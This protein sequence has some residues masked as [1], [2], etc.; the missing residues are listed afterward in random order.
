[1]NNDVTCVVDKVEWLA[2]GRPEAGVWPHMTPVVMINASL[3]IG[4]VYH[5]EH[6][7]GRC[8]RGQE[9]AVGMV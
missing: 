8:L 7:I 5:L 9:M 6:F 2:P 1:M 4:E 3:E